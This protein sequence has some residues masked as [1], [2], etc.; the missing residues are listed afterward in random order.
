VTIRSISKGRVVYISAVRLL[1]KV[2]PGRQI[3][4]NKTRWISTIHFM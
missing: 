3:F 2:S 1:V 4:I